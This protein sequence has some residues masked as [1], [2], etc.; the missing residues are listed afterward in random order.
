MSYMF[1]VLLFFQLCISV[2]SVHDVMSPKDEK[3]R[4]NMFLVLFVL[5][6]TIV[7]LLLLLLLLLPPPPPPSL[8]LV[9]SVF[10]VPF[11]IMAK[12]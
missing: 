6:F 3:K 4:R 9:V 7:F 2:R 11:L 12:S 8:H 5:S 10:V 1:L